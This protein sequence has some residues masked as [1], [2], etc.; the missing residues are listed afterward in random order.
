MY[1]SNCVLPSDGNCKPHAHVYCIYQSGV[2]FC[3]R[4]GFTA[5][6]EIKKNWQVLQICLHNSLCFFIQICSAFQVCRHAARIIMSPPISKLTEILVSSPYSFNFLIYIYG[7]T[8]QPDTYCGVL[9]YSRVWKHMAAVYTVHKSNVAH[10]PLLHPAVES[11][12]IE[13]RP[14]FFYIQEKGKTLCFMLTQV[15]SEMMYS[16]RN[17]QRTIIA[18]PRLLILFLPFNSEVNYWQVKDIIKVVFPEVPLAPCQNN[19][20]CIDRIDFKWGPTPCLEYRHL[21]S[22]C[23]VVRLQ[24]IFS[25]PWTEHWWFVIFLPFSSIHFSQFGGSLVD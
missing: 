17:K 7:K 15:W 24:Q 21:F 2:C 22:L 5:F 19:L 13:H 20:W 10:S 8:T 16:R 12:C 3:V 9:M 25:S 6:E 14:I 1:L 18:C 4:V 11:F 23:I